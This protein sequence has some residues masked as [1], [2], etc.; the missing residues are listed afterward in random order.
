M[1]PDDP[2]NPLSEPIQEIDVL[3]SADIPKVG[4]N[5]VVCN[6]VTLYH[7][8]ILKNGSQIM[9]EIYISKAR[10]FFEAGLNYQLK[11]NLFFETFFNLKKQ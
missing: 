2:D 3:A 5:G 6:P 8:V 9:T 10:L 7:N 1:N 11:N 4:C